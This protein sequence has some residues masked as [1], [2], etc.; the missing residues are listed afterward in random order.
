MPEFT[1]LTDSCAACGKPVRLKR[2][3]NGRLYY[4]C[5]LAADGC[6]T[7]VT[8]G[9]LESRGRDAEKHPKTPET[10]KEDKPDVDQPKPKRRGF[11]YDRH[12]RG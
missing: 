2:D 1:S 11:F 10:P 12:A 6:D 3:R 5:M 8:Y 9:L 7:A 4:R